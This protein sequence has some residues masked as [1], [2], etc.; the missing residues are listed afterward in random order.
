VVGMVLLWAAGIFTAAVIVPS[1]ERAAE[2][3]FNLAPLDTELVRNLRY[4]VP[5][6]L[7]FWLWPLAEIAPRLVDPRAPRAAALAGLLLLT[8]WTATHTPEGRR[9]ID[10]GVCLTHGRLICAPTA[11]TSGAV[12]AVREHTP[13][14]ARIF[15]FNVEDKSTSGMLS[16]RYDALR[17]LVYTVRDAG[18]YLYGQRARLPA[19]LAVTQRVDAIQAMSDPSARL[20]A[21]IPLARELGADYLIFDFPAEPALLARY[22][23][24]EVWRNAAF[25]LVQLAGK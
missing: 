21:L 24:I 14:G 1:G 2:L 8:A 18:T 9:L 16:I 5:L 19:W 4:L 7:L 23:V 13:P 12:L 3:A 15:N 25:T 17:P 11:D 20:E 22:P 10:A 6:M